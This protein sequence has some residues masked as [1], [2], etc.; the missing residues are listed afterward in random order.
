MQQMV[1]KTG[2][3]VRRRACALYLLLFSVMACLF[4]IPFYRSGRSLVFDDDG[5]K[6]HIK[7]LDF[8]GRYLRVLFAR[9]RGGNLTIPAYSLALGYGA[10][11]ITTLHYYVIGDP[12]NLLSVFFDTARIVWLYNA[13]IVLRMGLSG[14][15]FLAFAGYTLERRIS[16]EDSPGSVSSAGMAAGAVLYVFSSF[17]LYTAARHPFF[18]NPMIWFPLILLGVEKILREKKYLVLTCSVM[19]GALSNFYF[20]YMMVLLTV[21]YVVWR[22]LSEYGLSRIRNAF[23]GLFMIF[24]S[25]VLGVMLSCLLFWPVVQAFLSNPRIDNGYELNLRYPGIYYRKMAA[26]A[27]SGYSA[28]SWTFL[29]YTGIGAMILILLFLKFRKYTRYK[30]LFLALAGM[31]CIPLASYA[32]SGFSYVSNRWTWAVSLFM[33]WI[34]ALLWEDLQ[35]LHLMEGIVLALFLMGYR[36]LITMTDGGCWLNM[37]LEIRLAAAALAAVCICSWCRRRTKGP[38]SLRISSRIRLLTGSI[39]LILLCSSAAGNAWYMYSSKGQDF[40]KH[41]LPMS[42]MTDELTEDEI[43]SLPASGDTSGNAAD[44]SADADSASLLE[45]ADNRIWNTEGKAVK[46]AA[47]AQGERL[48]AQTGIREDAAAFCRYTGSELTKNGPVIDGLPSTQFYWSLS[49]GSVAGYLDDL[50][51]NTYR[52]YDFRGLDD[53]VMTNALAGVQYYTGTQTGR[54]PFG[55]ERVPETDNPLDAVYPVYRNT[56]AL[57]F[58]YTFDHYIREADYQNMDAFERQEAMLQGIVLKE[59]DESVLKDF[60]RT[61]PASDPQENALS[62]CGKPVRDAVSVP[63]QMEALD[64]NV[65]IGEGCFTVTGANA[66]VRFTFE[67]KEQSETCLYVR[68]L[69]V[70][71]GNT[72]VNLRIRAKDG[73]NEDIVKSLIYLDPRHSWYAGRHDFIVNMGYRDGALQELVLTF[74]KAGIYR[75]EQLEIVCQ[76]MQHLEEYISHLTGNTLQNVSYDADADTFSLS[77]ISGD[78]TL[79][80]PK[81]LCLAL[82]FSDGWTARVDG[83]TAPV[84][85]GNEMYLAI[86]MNEGTHHLELSYQTPG[87]AAGLLITFAGVLIFAGSIRINRSRKRNRSGQKRRRHG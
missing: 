5:I 70:E 12:L 83:E 8:Y 39:L 77:R 50:A 44:A 54:V 58:G 29:G 21:L 85:C 40:L 7:A 79:E 10:D 20:F 66:Q 57:P 6:Q 38:R 4:L 32:I 67:G 56:F 18:I 3:D 61:D 15:S 30:I 9:L 60:Y 47:E 41:Y 13:L 26:A 45:R 46:A 17:A 11:V 16:R 68:G 72:Q 33:A 59:A 19:F 76:G 43:L 25:S 36:L 84:L 1:P 81:I 55:Y 74:P 69:E 27:I 75:F 62:I 65:S 48:A 49:N 31:L 64:S 23:S 28:G 22:L 78:I 73:K 37:R 14:L 86:P 51:N 82:P 53:R 87:S 24:W 52:N 2:K 71:E 63:F 34:T 80:S 35:E 42:G